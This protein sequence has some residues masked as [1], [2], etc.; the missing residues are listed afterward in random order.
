MSHI[1]TPGHGPRLSEVNLHTL[2]SLWMEM[3]PQ[4]Q[5]EDTVHNQ[6][7]DIMTGTGASSPFSTL[8]KSKFSSLPRLS[9]VRGVGLVVVRDGKVVGLH[10]S[11]SELHA[12]QA[13][14]IQ[15]G[16]ALAGCQLYF[17]RRPCATCFKM[18]I[19]G[20]N[21]GSHYRSLQ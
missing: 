12:G 16:N 18:L 2:L 21:R 17:S 19:N 1:C 14:T 20:E 7:I 4:K 5:P 11:T 15:H 3:F 10:C 8:I 13:A 6:V 9:Q